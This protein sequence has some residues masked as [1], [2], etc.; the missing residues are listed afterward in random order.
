MSTQNTYTEDTREIPSRFYF[1]YSLKKKKKHSPTLSIRKHE[2]S[3]YFFKI[4]YYSTLV[5]H[6][7]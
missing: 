1:I 7:V 3:S 5:V 2:N 4:L 6:T